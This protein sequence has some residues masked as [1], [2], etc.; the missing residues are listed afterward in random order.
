MRKFSKKHVLYIQRESMRGRQTDRRTDTGTDT[1]TETDRASNWILPSC[2][3][4]RAASERRERK[5]S[6]RSSHQKRTLKLS[7]PQQ[8]SAE[9]NHTRGNWVTY[10]MTERSGTNFPAGD[11]VLTGWSFVQTQNHSDVGLLGNCDPACTDRVLRIDMGNQ[12][13]L[14][15]MLDI[16]MNRVLFRSGGDSFDVPRSFRQPKWFFYRWIQSTMFEA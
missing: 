15:K 13:L 3:P 1:D 2:H 14:D 16:V 4:H 12:I 7:T 5:P 10:N 6:A 11:Q 9:W 8:T